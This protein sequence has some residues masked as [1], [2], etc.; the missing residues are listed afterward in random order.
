[1]RQSVI[2]HLLSLPFVEERKSRFADAPA[3]WIGNREFAHFHGVS[4]LDLRLT[5]NEIRK[6]QRLTKSDLITEF[7]RSSSD[8]LRV[9]LGLSEINC[10]L[11]LIDTAYLRAREE[12]GI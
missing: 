8:W 4:W 6:L 1:M 2:Q 7:R 9:D 3:F 12:M 10:V 11:D 5:R